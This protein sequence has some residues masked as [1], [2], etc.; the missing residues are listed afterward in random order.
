MKMTHEIIVKV[1][2]T[3]LDFF[4]ELLNN[5]KISFQT[6]VQ[7]GHTKVSKK[8]SKPLTLEQQTFV[9]DLRESFKEVEAA[10]R[11][12]IQLQ[13]LESFLDQ[14]DQEIQTNTH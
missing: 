3:Q 11:G 1:P 2:D 7:N 9:E 13:S 4:K 8:S 6:P 10:E 14:L 12:E 5:L